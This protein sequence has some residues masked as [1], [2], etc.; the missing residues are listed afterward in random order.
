MDLA[1]GADLALDVSE[2]VTSVPRN[3]RRQLNRRLGQTLRRQRPGGRARAAGDRSRGHGRA[4]LE[5]CGQRREH[6]R[7]GRQRQPGGLLGVEGRAHRGHEDDG[8]GARHDRSAGERRRA[9][10]V[11]D[12][13]TAGMDRADFDRSA[14]RIP[15]RR[16]GRPEE[17]AELVAFSASDRIQFSTGAV[18][19]IS[20]RRAV[21]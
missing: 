19:D 12:G 10:A 3:A 8:Q 11:S 16:H 9:G 1:P 18:Y 17:A 15:M 2:A 21:Y 13:M 4:R 5:S 6:R 14:N 7:Q 20:G